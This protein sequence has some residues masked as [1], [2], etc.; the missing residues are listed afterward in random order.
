MPK[1]KETPMMPGTPM[2]PETPMDA[3]TAV[4]VFLTEVYSDPQA[5][6]E[7]RMCD[8]ESLDWAGVDDG[9][10]AD[11]LDDIGDDSEEGDDDGQ[12]PAAA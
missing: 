2:M 11:E 5:L 7:I 3:S 12:I 6:V 10:G 4:E 8:R 1:R 9:V